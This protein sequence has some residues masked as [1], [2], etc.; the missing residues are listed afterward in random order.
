MSASLS[1]VVPFLRRWA[2]WLLAGL[3]GAIIL[4][5]PLPAGGPAPATAVVRLEA[6]SFEYSPATVRVEPGDH[7]TLEVVATDV[8]HGLY[9][10]GYDLSVTA[11]PGQT[12]RISFVANKPGVFRFRCSVTC[13]PLHPFM[14]GKLYVGPG[15]AWW[16]GLAVLVG[17]ATAG[18][19]FRRYAWPATT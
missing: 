16:R 15:T 19:M 8:V 1:S 13:G 3:V 4:I 12:A 9:L 2:G 11:D 10:D 5:T 14:I 17:A 7:V 18:L 6:S